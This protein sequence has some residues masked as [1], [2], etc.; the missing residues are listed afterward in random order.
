MKFAFQKQ[1][2]DSKIILNIIMDKAK[3]VIPKAFF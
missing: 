2:K 1:E 3:T